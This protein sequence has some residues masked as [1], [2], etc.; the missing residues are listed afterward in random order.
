MP[1]ILFFPGF[2]REVWRRL[3][4]MW[5]TFPCE[6][7]DPETSLSIFYLPSL[8]FKRSKAQLKHKHLLPGW[9][10]LPL[11]SLLLPVH[12]KF[13]FLLGCPW[14]SPSFLGVKNLYGVEKL[15]IGKA[16]NK[17][18]SRQKVL[19]I[20]SGS[21]WEGGGSLLSLKMS[22]TVCCIF[23]SLGKAK[24]LCFK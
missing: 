10:W 20:E 9:L 14:S 3:L 4:I 12:P 1:I 13:T 5:E 6:N 15:N 18:K 2:H 22:Y 16:F 19:P 21:L 7:R 23:V 11:P 17:I 8:P 24:W